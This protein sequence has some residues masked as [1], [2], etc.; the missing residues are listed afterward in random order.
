MVLQAAQQPSTQSADE[1]RTGPDRL[2]YLQKTAEFDKLI[3]ICTS[4]IQ[5]RPDDERPLMIRASSYMK[6]GGH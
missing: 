5:A 3:E 4:N 6:K 2:I 1:R